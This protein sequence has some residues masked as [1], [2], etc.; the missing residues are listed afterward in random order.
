M[1]KIRLYRTGTRKRAMYRIVA[2]D[3]RRAR[4]GRPL[5]TLG[6]YDPRKPGQG[7][8]SI[9]LDAFDRWVEKGAQVSDTV[10]SLVRRSREQAA[11]PAEA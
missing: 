10:K 9:K 6:T 7:E 1:V 4:Q 8:V 2:I 3:E 11:A 5:E